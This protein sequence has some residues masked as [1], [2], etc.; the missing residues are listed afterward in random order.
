MVI[1][2]RNNL[3]KFFLD[4]F[5]LMMV[6]NSEI[7][8]PNKI[9]YDR[10][11]KKPNF[12]KG[13]LYTVKNLMSIRILYNSPSGGNDPFDKNIKVIAIIK[14]DSSSWTL[15]LFSRIFLENTKGE[16]IM[17]GIIMLKKI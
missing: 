12:S 7:E 2:I 1:V 13:I 14:K 3:K 4:N 10:V 16:K 5:E 6:T 11:T 8:M 15:I 9:E 17:T